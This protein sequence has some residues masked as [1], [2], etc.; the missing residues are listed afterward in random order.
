MNLKPLKASILA[1]MIGFSV[2]QVTI[3]R[4]ITIRRGIK[5]VRKSTNLIKKEN[6]AT[7][8]ITERTNHKLVT[9]KTEKSKKIHMLTTERKVFG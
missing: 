8:F 2:L 6:K 1:L 7:G 4:T 9:Q 3:H 5:M